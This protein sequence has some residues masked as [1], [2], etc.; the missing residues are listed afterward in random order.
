MHELIRGEPNPFGDRD[1]WFFQG[2]WLF[3]HDYFFAA[4]NRTAKSAPTELSTEARS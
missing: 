2:C 4:I 1:A 3:V